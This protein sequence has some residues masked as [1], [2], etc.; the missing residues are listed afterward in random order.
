MPEPSTSTILHITNPERYAEELE[1]VIALFTAG[2]EAKVPE[3]LAEAEFIELLNYF[4]DSLPMN[5]TWLYLGA[6]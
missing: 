3:I 2:E 4:I 6:R 5:V 1:G